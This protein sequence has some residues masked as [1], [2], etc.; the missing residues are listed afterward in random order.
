M[1]ENLAELDESFS[2]S[3]SVVCESGDF[4]DHDVLPWKSELTWREMFSII[5]PYL[6][7]FP[8]DEFVS[9]RLCKAILQRDNIDAGNYPMINEQDFNTVTV[10]MKALGLVT[11]KYSDSRESEACW[12]LTPHGKQLMMEVC[13]VKSELK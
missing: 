9:S 6:L 1:V 2:I 7:R 10:Q 11:T 8:D 3:G 5:A 12:S 13:T 4:G